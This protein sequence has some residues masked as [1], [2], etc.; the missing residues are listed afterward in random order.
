[1]T[2]FLAFLFAFLPPQTPNETKHATDVSDIV[3]R[4]ERLFAQMS[5]FSADFVQT[6]QNPL[7]RNQR[8]SGHLYLM[9]PRKMR[10]DYTNPD[11]QFVS[12]GKNVYFYVP[13]DRQVTKEAVK[14]TFDERMPLMFLVGRSNLSN[15]FTKFEELTRKPFLDGTRV[16]RMY[17]KRKTD[18][19]DVEIEVDPANYQIRRLILDHVD[20]SQ[21]DFIFS[22]IQTN[23]GL[24]AG[25]FE[26]KVPQ[27]VQVVQGI[28]Q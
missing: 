12:D 4:V 7:N 9:K 17:P 13:A 6:D 19:K 16:I 1:M 26:F 27:G 25:F 11:Q 14:E 2:L 18:I 5:D 10:W 28:G 22:N 3:H 20:G 15:E 21:S 23:T 8:A 24:K